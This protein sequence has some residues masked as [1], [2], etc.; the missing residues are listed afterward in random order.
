[1]E[2]NPRTMFE[3]LFG[4][5]GTREQRLLARQTDRRILDSVRDAA[6]WPAATQS[7]PPRKARSAGR[8]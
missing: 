2:I 5:S 3:R 7:R 4:R 1:M 6:G 8:A